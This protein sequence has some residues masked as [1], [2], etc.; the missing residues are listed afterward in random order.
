VE[1]DSCGSRNVSRREI[2]GHLLFECHLC[3][4]LSG[5]DAAILLIEELREGRARGLDDEVIPLV[6]VLEST[7]AFK[8]VHASIGWREKGEA[9]SILFS[10]SGGLHD[11]EKL[12]RSL[13]MATRE[14]HFRWLVELTLQHSVVFVLRPRFF[15]PP[16]EITAEEIEQAREDLGTLARRLRRDVSLSWWRA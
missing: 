5:D 10:A 3:G 4:D 15:K 8:L 2:E 12:L 1:C 13:E 16:L 6:S 14:T 9:P 11:I 7:R